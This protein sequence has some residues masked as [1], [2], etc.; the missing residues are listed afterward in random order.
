[1]DKE[2]KRLSKSKLLDHFSEKA[3][4]EYLTILTMFFCVFKFHVAKYS[5]DKSWLNSIFR[6]YGTSS[7][8]Q[9]SQI[10]EYF[11]IQLR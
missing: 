5:D 10:K 3:D 2:F 8:L 6:N 1:M 4:W 7:L 9:M 11:G